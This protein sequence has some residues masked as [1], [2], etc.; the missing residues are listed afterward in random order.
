MKK[1]SLIFILAFVAIGYASAQTV[2]GIVKD[3]ENGDEIIGATIVLKSQPAKGTTSGL[4]GSFA[5]N[6]E[7][8]P[9]TIIISFMGYHQSELEVKSP[10]EVLNILLTP[11]ALGLDEVV[12]V[13]QS[14]GKN[15]NSARTIEKMAGNVL[16]IVSARSMEISP[17]LTVASVIQRVSG[18][19]VERNSSGDGQ[20]AILRGM[21]KRYNYTLVNGVKIPSPDNKNR[22]VPLDIFP[23]EL[24]DRLEV[25]KALTADMEGDAIGGSVN[26]VMKDAPSSMQ[27][28]ANIATGYNALFFDRDFK[29]FDR[30]A[31]NKQSPFERYGSDYPAKV[32]DFTTKNLVVKSEQAKPN[33]FA[34]FSFGDRFFKD[35][36]GVIA[37]LSYQN[38]YRGNNSLYFDNVTASNN[39]S[40][41]PVLTKGSNR[42]YSEQQTRMGAHLKLDYNLSKNHKLQWY[43]AYMDFSNTQVREITSTDFSTG[44]DPEN[45]NYSQSYDTRLRWNHQSIFNSTLKGEHTFGKFSFDWA[46]VYSRAYNETPDNVYVYLGSRVNNNIPNAPSVVSSSGGSGGIKRR[47][48]NNS[49]EDLAGYLNFKYKTTAFGAKIDLSA[50]GM[51][52]DKA[53]TSFYNQYNFN[54]YDP[55]KPAG[56]QNNL[57]QG[58]DWQTFDQIKLS[59][60]NPYGSTGDPLNYDASEKIGSGYLQARADWGKILVIVGVRV[61]NTAQGYVLKHPTSGVTSDST[62]RYTDILPSL[63][64]KYIVHKDGNL[65]ASYYKSINR[66]SFFEIVPYRII[67]ED[68]QERGNPNLKHSIANN[69]DLRYEYFPRPSEQFMVGVFYKDLRNPIEMGI[70]SEGQNTY[71]MPSNYGTARNYG[72]EIDATKYFRWFG[73]KANYTYTHSKIITTKVKNIE[74]PD[75]SAPD[76]IKQITVEQSRPLNNQAAHVANLSLLV[77]QNGWDGQLAFSYTGERLYAISRFVDNDIWQ[78][79]FVQMDASVE[80]SFKIGI[81]VYAKASNLLNTPMIQFLK[82]QNSHN[83]D[84]AGYETYQ[85]G[86]LVRRDFY[87][88]TFQIGLKYKL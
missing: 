67:N 10:N 51:Y 48:E 58:T 61:E 49:D 43:N 13:G 71:Y 37:A 56:Q 4:D 39:T 1:I 15:D 33:L 5:F 77:K 75:P 31:I 7:N 70:Y 19:T 22:F 3:A 50:G 83:A 24:L 86:T 76:R 81:S 45:G 68:Y 30:R 38:S 32:Q 82:K 23:S 65:R 6:T 78:A 28:T 60:E 87:G 25:T 84:V 11:N 42:F 54:P 73:I 12:V 52:R 14:N 34:G 16:N 35:K 53:R 8:L 44:Y 27:I 46:G 36:L 59:L 18:V 40:N 63:H 17:D 57:I 85:G 62:Q 29:T 55:S 9:Q 2:K 41:L 88:Q 26:M 79:G 74:N 20:Y 64:L 21:D 72:V 69:V 66:P 80:K 47:W